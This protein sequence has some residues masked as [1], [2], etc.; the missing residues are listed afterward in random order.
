MKLRDIFLP[1]YTNGKAPA[2]YY[3]ERI[4]SSLQSNDA[5]DAKWCANKAILI[6]PPPIDL[7]CDSFRNTVEIVN[8]FVAYDYF[9]HAR[10][11][12]DSLPPGILHDYACYV[13]GTALVENGE[14]AKTINWINQ[15]TPECANAVLVQFTHRILELVTKEKSVDEVTRLSSYLDSAVKFITPQAGEELDVLRAI[16]SAVDCY[17]LLG[18]YSD[19]AILLGKI[20]STADDGETNNFFVAK[21]LEVHLC[22]FNNKPAKNEPLRNKNDWENSLK[23]AIRSA[24]DQLKIIDLKLMPIHLCKEPNRWHTWQRMIFENVLHLIEL[25]HPSSIGELS[26]NFKKNFPKDFL[27]RNEDVIEN[28]IK[29]LCFLIKKL[30]L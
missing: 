8:L 11:L 6:M 20:S 28:D 26:E 13:V 17:L 24:M 22:Y 9:R 12:V 3:R 18:R 10:D 14:F 1:S 7:H 30:Y 23:K 19:A 16:E 15:I 4:I 27:I 2:V 21:F 25:K 29:T 5:K